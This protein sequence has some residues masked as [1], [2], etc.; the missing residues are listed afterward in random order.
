[1][2]SPLRMKPGVSKGGRWGWLLRISV[3]AAAI[4]AMPIG[5][6]MRK[7]QRQLQCV[8]IQPPIGGPRTGATRAGQVRIA[9]TRT[10]S[11]FGV[12]RST[13]SRPT[14]TIIAPP[15][16]CSVRAAVKLHSPWVSAHRTEAPVKT[17]M[18]SMNMRRAPKRSAAQ[19][20]TGMKTVSA[21][22]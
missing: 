8:L 5:T 15:M 3:H 12:S 18:A 21:T 9:I 20:L 6:L 17:A 2:P 4:A 16:P 10:M 13:T 11:S 22:R 7:I 19:L 14:G 1:M